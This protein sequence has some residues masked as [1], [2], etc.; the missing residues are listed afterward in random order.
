MSLEI[1]KQFIQSA[2]DTYKL[3]ATN[4]SYEVAVELFNTQRDI[5]ATHMGDK[6]EFNTLWNELNK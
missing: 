4:V 3:L 2:L 1:K 6:K 5:F